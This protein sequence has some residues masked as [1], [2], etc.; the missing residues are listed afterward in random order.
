[1]NPI[2]RNIALRRCLSTH[3]LARSWAIPGSSPAFFSTFPA[4]PPRTFTSHSSQLICSQLIEDRTNAEQ[5]KSIL[6]VNKLR[7]KPVID[8]ID[9][10][11]DHLRTH[12][13]NVRVFHE[14]RR[15]IPRDVEVWRPGDDAEKIDLVITLGGDGTILHASSLFKVGAVPP[16]LS[17]SMGTLGFLLPFHVDDFSKALESV[18]QGK[19]TVLYRMRL[20]CAF[21]DNDGNKLSKEGEGIFHVF[22]PSKCINDSLDWQVMNE[23]ALHRGSSPHLNTID[24]YVDGQHLTEAV[25]DGLIVSTPTGSTAY[26]LS[27]GGPIVHPSLSALV[28]TPICPR[29]LSFRPLVFPA[30]SSITLRI[31]DRSRAPAGVSM[32]GQASHVLNPGESVTVRASLHPI[33]CINRSSISDPAFD[34]QGEGAG[35]G[36]EDDWVRD[37]N[38]LLQYNATFRSKALLRHSRV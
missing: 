4:P 9:S 11:L 38:N 1:M 20:S 32:D 3:S 35:P 14:D 29:S 12:Y 36:K 8:T 15:D 33:P 31:G 25:S 18:F 37:I 26:S 13:P 7:T 10:F 19:A 5:A 17:F 30:S 2:A 28:L 16:V 22:S 6:I 23:V 34:S 27:A 24:A 21:L